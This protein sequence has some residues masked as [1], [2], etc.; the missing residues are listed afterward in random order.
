L[1]GAMDSN[2]RSRSFGGESGGFIAVGFPSAQ[3]AAKPDREGL[4]SALHQ[5]DVCASSEAG[6]PVRR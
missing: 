5:S 2:L 6:L 4:A 1:A 3:Y